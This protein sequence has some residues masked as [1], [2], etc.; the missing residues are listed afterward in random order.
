M[1]GLIVAAAVALQPP[2]A[3]ADRGRTTAPS[4]ELRRYPA[5]EANRLRPAASRSFR[6]VNITEELQFGPIGVPV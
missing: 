1:L 5:A 6:N 4:V 3:Q 2:A